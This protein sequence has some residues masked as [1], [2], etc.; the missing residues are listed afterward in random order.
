MDLQFVM[1]GFLGCKLAVLVGRTVCVPCWK[2]YR[3]AQKPA[4]KRNIMADNARLAAAIV[5]WTHGLSLQR[6][7]SISSC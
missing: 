7:C 3:K 4:R 1:D 5:P 6:L 2:A